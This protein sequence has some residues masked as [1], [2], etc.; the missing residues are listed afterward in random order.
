MSKPVRID[1]SLFNAIKGIQDAMAKEGVKITFKDAS[2]ILY[3]NNSNNIER[4]LK[5][6]ED[7]ITFNFHL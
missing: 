7:E 2:K 4:T 6:I 3:R 1:V 5:K